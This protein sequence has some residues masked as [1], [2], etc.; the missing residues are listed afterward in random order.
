MRFKSEK[1]KEEHI[2]KNKEGEVDFHTI[3]VPHT[4]DYSRICYYKRNV[5]VKMLTEE[6]RVLRTDHKMSML[7]I[8]QHLSEHFQKN[9]FSLQDRSYMEYVKSR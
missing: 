6:I 9:I 1:I 7:R 2:K 8:P 3:E 5:T 4:Q